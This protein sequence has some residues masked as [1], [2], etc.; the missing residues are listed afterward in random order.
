MS[1]S[2]DN[3]VT[4]KIKQSDREWLIDEQQRLRKTER[5]EPAHHEIFSRL[6][7]SYEAE[8]RAAAGLPPKE[9]KETPQEEHL[10]KLMAKDHAELTDVEAMIREIIDGYL[11]RATMPEWERKAMI[12]A[13]RKK[14]EEEGR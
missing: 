10:R 3:L 9:L 2:A 1:E 14:Y 13:R 6:R 5:R 4:L 12:D 7:S 11:K 8:L